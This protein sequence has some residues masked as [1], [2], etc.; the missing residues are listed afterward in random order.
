MSSS[1]VSWVSTRTSVTGIGRIN[2]VFPGRQWLGSKSVTSGRIGVSSVGGLGFR[3]RLSG[4]SGNQQA[5]SLDRRGSCHSTIGQR[6][7]DDWAEGTLVEQRCPGRRP[8]R[9][10]LGSAF[11]RGRVSSGTEDF[12]RGGQVVFVPIRGDEMDKRSEAESLP[13]VAAP[14]TARQKWETPV[15]VDIDAV[16]KTQSG[17]SPNAFNGESVRYYS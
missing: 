6:H 14:E 1:Q 2:R 7:R 15:L 12:G 8:F 16:S 17:N 5:K 9:K 4:W 11:G 10:Q 13:A 3:T